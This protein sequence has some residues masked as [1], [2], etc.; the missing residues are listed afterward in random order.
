MPHERQNLD[1][2][3]TSHWAVNEECCRQMAK[4]YGWTLVETK[5]RA[6]AGDPL[7]VEC[8][9]EGDCPFPNRYGEQNQ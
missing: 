4:K 7:V 8:I 5:R 2:D 3:N 1:P 9:F 6:K